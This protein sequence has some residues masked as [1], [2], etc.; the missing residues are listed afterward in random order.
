VRKTDEIAK[1]HQRGLHLRDKLFGLA[2]LDQDAVAMYETALRHVT[3]EQAR[4]AF[5]QFQK[6][7]TQHLDELV[8]VI[9]HIGWAT[10]QFRVDLKG[11]VEKA[12]AS[13]RGVT[14]TSGSIHAVWMAEKFHN[15]RYR[16]AAE[17]DVD[18]PQLAAL[19]EKFDKDEKRHLAFAEERIRQESPRK[20]PPGS[21]G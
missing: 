9:H 6:E 14:G 7:H 12:V 2:Q 4:T 11:H 3:D 21:A 5:R 19:L 17:W 20:R 18:D 10:P 8:A 15:R 1:E 13:T 16:E